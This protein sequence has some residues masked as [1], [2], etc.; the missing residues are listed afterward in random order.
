ML[1]V[2]HTPLSED[3][4]HPH[5]ADAIGKHPEDVPHHIGGGQVYDQVMPVSG[6][7]H[8]SEGSVAAQIHPG[9]GSGSVG[10]FS[11]AGALPG[12]ERVHHIGD[13][14]GQI[15]K[16]VPGVDVFGYRDK[17]DALFLKVMLDVHSHLSVLPP[18]SREVF[19]DDHIDFFRF[20]C[21]RPSA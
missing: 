9:F 7:L 19:H 8:I 16:A 14:Q 11:F 6:A 1:R 4:G 10:G 2:Q 15:I 3:L 5:I 20:Q 12:V 18:K 21:H 17:A 13:R